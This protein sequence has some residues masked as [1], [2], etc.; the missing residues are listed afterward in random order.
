MAFAAEATQL[1]AASDWE[2]MYPDA[3]LNSIVREIDNK[4]LACE[5]KLRL[6]EAYPDDADVIVEASGG[7]KK[8]KLYDLDRCEGYDHRFS[9]I[10]MAESDI[11]KL[12][13]VSMRRLVEAARAND[14]LYKEGDY[15]ELGDSMARI[16]G[17]IAYAEDR[18][19]FKA[20]DIMMDARDVIVD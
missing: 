8:I 5:V 4:E 10:I 19:E 6:M 11:S 18:G 17:A 16:A 7:L 1:Y 15:A 3:G 12:N 9:A 20:A 13:D 14:A 2:N